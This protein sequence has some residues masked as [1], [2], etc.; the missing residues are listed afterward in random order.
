MLPSSRIERQLIWSD[1]RGC[2]WHYV[3]LQ[4]DGLSVVADIVIIGVDHRGAPLRGQV[5]LVYDFNWRFRQF[6]GEFLGS[7]PLRLRLD[8]DGCWLSGMG[9]PMPDLFGAQDV[10][11]SRVPVCWG[12]IAQRIGISRHIRRESSFSAV[13]IDYAGS[14]SMEMRQVRITD[15]LRVKGS[16]LARHRISRDVIGWPETEIELDDDLMPLDVPEESRRIYPSSDFPASEQEWRSPRVERID[17][18]DPLIRPYVDQDERTKRVPQHGGMG[19]AKPGTA[20][21]KWKRPK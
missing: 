2:L 13:E 7:Q 9:E 12:I 8:E 6:G 4:R 11:L 10:V 1:W 17:D 5:R 16:S 3:D 14:W 21:L 19:T 15:R 18:S 20:G